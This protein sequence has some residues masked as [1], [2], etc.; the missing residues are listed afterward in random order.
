METVSRGG[1]APTSAVPSGPSSSATSSSQVNVSKAAATKVPLSP[2]A[3]STVESTLFPLPRDLTFD[4]D[5]A[6]FRAA[7]RRWAAPLT[8]LQTLVRRNRVN[9]SPLQ[10]HIP[11]D[12]KILTPTE[13]K[14]LRD[15]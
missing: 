1:R 13:E 2:E 15:Q 3:L 14:I 11:S 10:E 8:L 6:R 12:T 5:L 9:S 4:S 7:W